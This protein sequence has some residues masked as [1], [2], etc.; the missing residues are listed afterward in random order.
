MAKAPSLETLADRAEE[1]FDS[2]I[3]QGFASEVGHIR[4]YI[5]AQGEHWVQANKVHRKVNA[6]LLRQ[7]KERA[8]T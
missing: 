4:T 2:L 1:A 3:E 8:K 6:E 5:K 7:L